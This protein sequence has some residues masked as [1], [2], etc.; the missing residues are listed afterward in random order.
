MDKTFE[1][2]KIADK[3]SKIQLGRIFDSDTFEILTN[4]G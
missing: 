4:I 3:A 2:N 1:F